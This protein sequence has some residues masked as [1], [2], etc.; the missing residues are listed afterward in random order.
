MTNHLI[1]RIQGL[2]STAKNLTLVIEDK[3]SSQNKDA[4]QFD[5]NKPMKCDRS[6]VA[7]KSKKPHLAYLDGIRG[8]AAFY[9]VLSHIRDNT[10]WVL[11]QQNVSLA[12]FWKQYLFPVL[13]HGGIAVIAFIVLSGYCLTLPILHSPKV[14]F[15][16]GIR[17]YIKRRALRILPAY[18][19]SLALSLLLIAYFPGVQTD[20]S[21]WRVALPAFTP[22]VLLSHLFLVHNLSLNWLHKINPPT[23][24]MATEWQLYFT[25]PLLILIW[26]RFGVSVMVITSILAGILIRLLIP[27]TFQAIPWLL[28]CFGLGVG[29]AILNFSKKDHTESSIAQERKRLNQ[30]KWLSIVTTS[31]ATILTVFDLLDRPPYIMTTLVGIATASV[32]MFLT[33]YLQIC[34]KD[35]QMLASKPLL[36]SFLESKF[37]L[38][39]GRFSYSLYLTHLPV[40]STVQLVAFQHGASITL[41]IV[42]MFVIGVPLSLIVAS[43]F[44]KMFEA[45]FLKLRNKKL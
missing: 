39:L 38:T 25:L 40:L 5:Q 19:A 14:W 16:G 26:K 20:Q 8:I 37:S 6:I 29:A 3:E 9:I 13:S 41:S 36:L 23:W 10:K 7:L 15:E 27:Q 31:I 1:K 43:L 12:P 45:P 33:Q 32:I 44:Y 34:Q 18:Y 28:G 24:S 35:S 22:D 21:F 11:E 4:L 2:R 30:L 17:R 42:L